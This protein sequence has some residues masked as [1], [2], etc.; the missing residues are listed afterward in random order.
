[1]DAR[2]ELEKDIDRRSLRAMSDSKKSRVM[3]SVVDG[4]GDYT[5]LL[6]IALPDVEWTGKL[7]ISLFQGNIVG[8]VTKF[9]ETQAV[10]QRCGTHEHVTEVELET[11]IKYEP[12]VK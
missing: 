1:M 10:C 6:G 2:A 9:K 7:T 3:I 4:N 11:G 12:V 5:S 8:K